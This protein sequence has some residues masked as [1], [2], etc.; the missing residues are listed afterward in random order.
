MG[1]GLSIADAH[2][3]LNLKSS[4]IRLLW[5]IGRSATEVERFEDQESLPGCRLFD[6]WDLS[7]A[8]H[9]VR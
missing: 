4:S 6:A 8:D 5:M 3:A 1:N 9:V 7:A 2:T